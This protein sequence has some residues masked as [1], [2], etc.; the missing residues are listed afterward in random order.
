MHVTDRDTGKQYYLDMT[1]ELK[2]DLAAYHGGHCEHSSSEVRQRRDGEGAMHFYCQCLTCGKSIGS[3]LRKVPELASSPPWQDDL[4]NTFHRA[5]GDEYSDLI[6]K[7]VRI[8]KND[9]EG[10]RREYD[11]YLDSP[12]WRE[13]RTRVLKRANGFAKDA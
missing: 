11:R 12:E 8:Q 5:R 9:E 3:A 7:H 6:Q 4:E 10:F 2:A 13:K 1:P